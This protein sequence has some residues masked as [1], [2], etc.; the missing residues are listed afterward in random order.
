MLKRTI[1]ATLSY[2][3][4]TFALAY[5][6]HLIWFHDAYLKMGAFTRAE[7]IIPFGVLAIIIQGLV[8]AYFY[9][10]WYRGGRP[11]ASGI[12][13]SLV[14]G[15]LIYSVMGFTTVAKFDINPIGK[16]LAYHTVFQFLQFTITGAVLGL[17]FADPRDSRAR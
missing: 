14:I 16:F 2:L 8:I 13:Y 17:I 9:P 11:I 15:L 10:F 3:V 6:W 4:L 1:L 5:P 7:T 12:Q